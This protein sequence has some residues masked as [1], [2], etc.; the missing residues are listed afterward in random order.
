MQA[1]GFSPAPHSGNTGQQSFDYGS[2]GAAPQVRT[3]SNV[4]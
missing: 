4:I 1:L 2:V 3:M